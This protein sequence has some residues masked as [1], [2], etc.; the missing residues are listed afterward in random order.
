MPKRKRSPQKIT[1]VPTKSSKMYSI[2]EKNIPK[3]INGTWYCDDKI[4]VYSYLDVKAS[5]KIAGFDLDHTIIKPIGGDVHP[6]HDNDWEFFFDNIVTKFKELK[7]EG[8]KIVIFT[9]QKAISS[10]RKT[11]INLKKR[12]EN[13]MEKINIPLQVFISTGHPKFRKPSRG[14]WDL[15]C[16]EYNDDICVDLSDSFYVGDGAG[17]LDGPS[18][19][20][21]DFTDSDKLFSLNIGIDFKTPEEFFKKMKYKGAYYDVLFNPKNLFN[22]SSPLLI[23]EN[24]KI[25]SD[26]KEILV[27]VGI[28]GS[29]KSFFVTKYLNIDNY[30]VINDSKKLKSNIFQ[31]PVTAIEEILNSGKNIVVDEENLEKLT[32]KFWIDIAKKLKINIRCFYFDLYIYHCCHNIAYKQIIGECKYDPTT[33]SQ[34][35]RSQKM[36]EPP[37]YEEGFKDIIKVNFHPHFENKEYANIYKSYLPL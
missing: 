37:I 27:L 3:K 20:R 10:K 4:W 15:L 6:K 17:R 8:F 18:P 26:E 36:L 14:M 16:N 2:F 13:I 19:L 30:H 1:E 34:V 31:N 24:S 32:R 29:G 5:K 12:I 35:K 21:K 11:H 22:I 25:T 23:P 28:M 7:D 9:N 33:K